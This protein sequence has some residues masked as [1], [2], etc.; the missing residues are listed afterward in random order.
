MGFRGH[1]GVYIGIMENKME[2]T[3]VYWGLY[4]DN[5]KYIGNYYSILYVEIFGCQRPR[6]GL[7][8]NLIRATYLSAA[9]FDSP[10]L[11]RPSHTS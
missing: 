7:T 8:A 10:L 3:I 4:W 6:V 1:I 11:C 2:T 9:H 5:G